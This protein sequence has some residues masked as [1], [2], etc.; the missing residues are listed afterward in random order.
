MG[1]VRANNYYSNSDQNLKTNIIDRASVSDEG[2]AAVLNTLLTVKGYT[3]DWIG[4]GNPGMGVIAQEVQ[5]VYPTLVKTDGNDYK[6]VLY[7]AFIAP[8]VTSISA[9][10]SMITLHSQ[11]LLVAQQAAISALD[12]RIRNLERR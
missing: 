8:I 11:E 10:N 7:S 9:L 3:F 5:E 12:G 4:D 6:S 1:D 2:A